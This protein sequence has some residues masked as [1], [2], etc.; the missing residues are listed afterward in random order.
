MPTRFGVGRLDHR[1]RHLAETLGIR[2]TRP[3]AVHKALVGTLAGIDED[4]FAA[5][6]ILR[7]P[8]QGDQLVRF[9]EELA[10][11]PSH[12]ETQ[13]QLEP[14]AGG[15]RTGV[16]LLNAGSEQVVVV[17]AL[18]GKVDRFQGEREFLG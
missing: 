11:V 13:T 8:L 16:V 10:V 17:H 1:Q 15:D 7:L 2:P 5:M 4:V 6:V 14:A 12:L 3:S 9:A 18:V